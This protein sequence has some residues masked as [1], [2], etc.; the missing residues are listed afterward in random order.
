[1]ELSAWLNLS[2]MRSVN[3]AGM[4]MPVSRTETRRRKRSTLPLDDL[5]G[6]G[7]C[8]RGSELDGVGH[9]V[10]DDLAQAQGIGLRHRR[11]GRASSRLKAR[12]LRLAA[13][14]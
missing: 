8:Y 7:R 6:Q 9:Q 2:K 1:M 10:V 14:R 11:Q 3:S 4:P 5:G 12:A 13:T